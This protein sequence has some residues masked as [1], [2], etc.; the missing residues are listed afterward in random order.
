MRLKFPIPFYL[1]LLLATSFLGKVSADPIP[2]PKAEVGTAGVEVHYQLPASGTLPCT[3]R[4][5]L[6]AV[7][8]KDPNW[9]ISTFA[10]GVV[11]TVTAENQ[12]KFTE[13]WDG[14]DDNYMPVPP[15]A[16]ALKGIYMPAQTWAIDGEYHSITPKL[17]A[18][19][20]SWGQSPSEDFK[21]SKVDGDP[22]GSPFRDVDVA[23]NGKGSAYFQYLENGFNYFL[24]DFTKPIGYDQIITGYNSGSFAGG[25]STCTDGEATWCSSADGGVEFVARPD[26]KPFGK[27]QA[28]RQNV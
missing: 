9:I 2:A 7:D 10:A 12:G 23:P 20:S 25:V 28:T 24:T 22:C 15:G 13:K 3:Y 6:A 18:M 17:A 26:G 4:V 19:G 5:T 14:L 27:Q 8:P 1:S 16:Y 11:R 21:P